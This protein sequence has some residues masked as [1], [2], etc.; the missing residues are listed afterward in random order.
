[1]Y[2][3]HSRESSQAG[4][5]HSHT[6][7]TVVAS[8]SQDILTLF[9]HCS[10]GRILFAHY[11]HTIRTLFL[12]PPTIR[13]VALYSHSR[14]LFAHYLHGRTLFAGFTHYSRHRHTIFA[15]YSDSHKFAPRSHYSLGGGQPVHTHSHSI[16]T[17]SRSSH[18]FACVNVR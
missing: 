13:T 15:H 14:T 17:N 12:W 1:M 6:I 4:H 3:S 5:T 2:L 9:A 7:R 18:P 16:R 8:Y 11:S 10:H